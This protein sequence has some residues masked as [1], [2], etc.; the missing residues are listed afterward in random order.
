MQREFDQE[1]IQLI[2]AFEKITGSEVRDCIKNDVIHFLVNPGKAAR[3]I[4]KGGQN[5][6]AAENM[7]KKQIKIYEWSEDPYEFMNNL[8]PRAAK[9]EISNEK[10]MILLNP[11]QRGAVIGK[12][13]ANIKV[14]REFVE[15]NS[16]L[17][18]LKVV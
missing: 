15:R 10:A 7:L 18:G 12:G 3:T 8:V 17:K 14:L 9:I 2:A 6:R 4:G 1:T 11:K 13:G 16:P 5:V